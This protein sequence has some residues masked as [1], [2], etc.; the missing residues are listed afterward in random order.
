MAATRLPF[1]F[2]MVTGLRLLP[3]YVGTSVTQTVLQLIT[4][5]GSVVAVAVSASALSASARVLM[6]AMSVT[7][8][9][10]VAMTE[11]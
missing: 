8:V 7:P 1:T 3:R 9:C 2:H 10:F 6:V 5:D 4:V 11:S